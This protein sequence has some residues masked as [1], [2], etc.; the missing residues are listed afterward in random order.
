VEA[1]GV[2]HCIYDE[3][4]D[5]GALVKL[6]TTRA[7]HVEPDAEGSWWA[8]MGPSGGPML[9]PYGSRSEAEGGFSRYF[10]RHLSPMASSNEPLFP[11]K[12]TNSEFGGRGNSNAVLSGAAP[13]PYLFETRRFVWN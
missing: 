11:A 3:T 6:Q 1:D 5:L 4:L 9:G 13:K 7:S 2:A 10:F 12:P 8:D